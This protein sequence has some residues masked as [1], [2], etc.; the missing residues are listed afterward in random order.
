MKDQPELPYGNPPTQGHAGSDTSRE[1][2]EREANDGTAKARQTVTL[3]LVDGSGDEGVTWKELADLT[4]WH[5][6]QASGVLSVLHKSGR[7]AR[8]T[9]KRHRCH[10]YV[11]PDHVS[12]RATQPHGPVGS[13]RLLAE[14]EAL[15]V[16]QGFCQHHPLL[17]PDLEGCWGCR[18]I[19]LA[20]RIN[21]ALKGRR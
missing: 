20:T 15:L 13:T 1:R 9:E 5:H 11:T 6:G 16:E 18:A 4:R 21:T 7:I 10:V 14:A 12:G 3:A 2:A 17:F 8:L 19:D